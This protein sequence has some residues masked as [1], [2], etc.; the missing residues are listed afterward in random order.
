VG[1]KEEE[2]GG[3]GMSGN[4]GRQEGEKWWRGR[5]GEVDRGRKGGRKVRGQVG[6]TANF[7]LFF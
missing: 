5:D 4:G 2:E 6:K 1:A 7:V 3:N